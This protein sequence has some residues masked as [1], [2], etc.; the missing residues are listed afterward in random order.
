MQ[1][2]CADVFLHRLS[3]TRVE[4]SLRLRLWKCVWGFGKREKRV[5][6]P[7]DPGTRPLGPLRP[8]PP[9]PFLPEQ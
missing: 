3:I 5:N 7:I 1:R 6:R 4:S 9:Y 2:S 8:A